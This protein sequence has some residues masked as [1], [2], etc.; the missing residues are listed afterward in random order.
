MSEPT[1][2]DPDLP[3]Q[4]PTQLYYSNLQEENCT[5]Y[6]PEIDQTSR[7]VDHVLA[8]LGLTRSTLRYSIEG[9]A[10]SLSGDLLLIAV[11]GTSGTALSA[12]A[13]NQSGADRLNGAIS[14]EWETMLAALKR[15]E[16][17]GHPGGTKRALINGRKLREGSPDVFDV[18]SSASVLR[19]ENL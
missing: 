19:L 5:W 15:G 3:V 4:D 17:M 16:W 9:F 11:S 13:M 8:L 18:I 2:E 1:F 14:A 10:Q 12:W 6:V 7:M